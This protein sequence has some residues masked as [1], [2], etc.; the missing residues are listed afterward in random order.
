[1]LQV[2]VEADILDRAASDEDID[3]TAYQ[4][5]KKRILPLTQRN[6]DIGLWHQY[7]QESS[8]CTSTSKKGSYLNDAHPNDGKTVRCETGLKV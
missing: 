3:E 2:S 5:E 1:M 8:Q 7:R 4:K 6:S